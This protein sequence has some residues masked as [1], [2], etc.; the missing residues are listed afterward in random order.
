MVSK[1]I[2]HLFPEFDNKVGSRFLLEKA[3]ESEGNET[4]IGIAAATIDFLKEQKEELEAK[5]EFSAED[6]SLPYIKLHLFPKVVERLQAVM[7]KEGSSPRK[8]APKLKL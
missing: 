2:V 1:R 3:L 7:E 4:N 8:F 6:M 5:Q